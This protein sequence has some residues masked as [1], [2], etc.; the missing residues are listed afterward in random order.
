V[1]VPQEE[2]GAMLDLDSSGH[3]DL[4]G[5]RRALSPR[6]TRDHRTQRHPCK[7]SRHA[8]TPVTGSP[9]VRLSLAP[10]CPP[11]PPPP[12]TPSSPA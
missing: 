10:A 5:A 8:R 1:G 3:A 4:D 12:R 11:P 9:L 7:I 6:S 2:L